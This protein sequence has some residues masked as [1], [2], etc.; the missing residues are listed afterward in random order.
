MIGDLGRSPPRWATSALALLAIG[1]AATAVV[2]KNIGGQ[3]PSGHFLNV[4]YDPTRELYR[5][6]DRAFSAEYTRATGQTLTVTQSHGGSSRQARAVIGGLPADVVTLAMHSD[7]VALQRHGLIAKGWEARLPNGSRPYTSTI[8]FVVRRG[9]PRQIRDW[10]DLIKPGVVLVTPDPRTSGNGKLSFLAAWGSV[11]HGGGDEAHARAFVADLYRHAGTL[12]EGARGAATAFADEKI[13][14]VHLTWENEALREV[15]DAKG[16][17]EIVYPRSSILAEPYVAWVDANVARKGT[18]AVAKGY[19]EFLFTPAAQEIIAAHGYRPIDP[20]VLAAH[21]D[22]FPTVDLFPVT[23]LARDWE[24]AEQKF[25]GDGGVFER[26]DRSGSALA[27]ERG[28][29]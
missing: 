15:D 2:A 5:D 4:S 17:L 21:A 28:T 19:L 12:A 24:E 14:D 13:G 27:V 3:D 29:R 20:R 18:G 6:V 25:F 9:N 1:A 10:P 22:R 26:L 16:D 7:V 11:V 8:V 23:L